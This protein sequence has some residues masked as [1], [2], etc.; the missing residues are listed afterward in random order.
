MEG[1]ALSLAEF[2]QVI[3]K[4][5]VTI[6]VVTLLVAAAGAAYALFFR[7]ATFTAE[8]TLEIGRVAG[9]PLETAE[10]VVSAWEPV[11]DLGAALAAAGVDRPEF[12][13]S[14]PAREAVSLR[15]VTPGRGETEAELV[16]LSS[17]REDP[18]EA[19]AQVSALGSL[20][21][22]AHREKFDSLFAI[23]DGLR[24]EME[25]DL[26]RLLEMIERLEEALGGMEDT[27]SE[28]SLEYLLVDAAIESRL[29]ALSEVRRQLGELRLSLVRPE[30]FPTG[31]LLTPAVSVRAN[32]PRRL[33]VVLAAFGLGLTVAIT[34]AFAREYLSFSG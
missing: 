8:A 10:L 11:P 22:V 18:R 1:D 2:V 16:K 19:A 30:T 33:M 27:G 13:P 34:I 15:P 4:R 3:R 9:V 21:I 17:V 5:K 31:F 6:A 32:P 24:R 20:I 7:P 26:A 28:A 29:R 14:E 23:R 12:L 25:E